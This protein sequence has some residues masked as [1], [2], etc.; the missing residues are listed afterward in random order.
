MLLMVDKCLE[1][2]SSYS[3]TLIVHF[4]I[5][6]YSEGSA[7]VF[8]REMLSS[9]EDICFTLLNCVLIILLD[10]WASYYFLSYI[11]SFKWIFCFA[12]KNIGV[13]QLLKFC[14]S[15]VKGRR[16]DVEA[17]GSFAVLSRLM[18]FC[19]ASGVCCLALKHQKID[20]TSGM[21]MFDITDEARGSGIK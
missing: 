18:F 17:Y 11:I 9:E 4:L 3:E 8:Q 13:S 6:H 5:I 16:P 21:N 15:V 20:Q 12:G 10:F 19:N 2:Q 7:I 1:C 14:G